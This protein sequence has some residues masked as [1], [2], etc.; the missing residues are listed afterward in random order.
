MS[1]SVIFGYAAKEV[2]QPLEPFIYAQPGMGINDV[3]VSVTHCGLCHTDIQAIDDFYEITEYPFVPGHEIVGYV[4]QVGSAVST[5][6]VGD[7]VGIGW[8]GRSCMQCEWC[9]KGQEEMCMDIVNSATWKPYGG[10][11]S[12]VVVDHRFAYPLPEEMPS[13][14]A[15]V[16]MCAGISV[17]TPLH[18]YAL[19][20]SL[21]VAIMGVGGLGHLAIQFSHA[22]KHEVTVISSSSNKMEQAISFGADHF[23]LSTDEA[24]L[25]QHYFD[26]DILLITATGEL[27][28]YYLLNIVKK[29]GRVILV[30]FP[31]VS[32]HP[33]DLVAHN[34]SITGSFLGNHASMG[35]MLSFAQKHHITPMVETMPVSQVNEAIERVRENKVR[36]RI[37]LVN[38]QAGG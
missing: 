2:G 26:F 13:E 38:E 6:K 12:S 34:L 3:R 20:P 16:L 27:P 1:S 25:R 24:G 18:R 11:S 15:A 30:S 35:E 14:F 4:S 36:Y 23:I 8:Q 31:D 5:L 10:F 22:L 7:R 17:F 29:E 21:K 33:R 28:W 37:V 32:M 19:Q 9:L